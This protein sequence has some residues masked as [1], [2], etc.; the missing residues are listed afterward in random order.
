VL[1][2]SRYPTNILAEAYANR[3]QA[4]GK[5]RK[6]TGRVITISV[7]N[8]WHT[9]VLMAT[10]VVHFSSTLDIIMNCRS[11]HWIA[12][13]VTLHIPTTFYN[14]KIPFEGTIFSAIHRATVSRGTFISH[15][16]SVISISIAT[17]GRVNN[18]YS[19]TTT[20]KDSMKVTTAILLWYV[21]ATG[22]GHF[23]IEN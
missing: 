19:G 18:V 22:V 20:M 2:Y 13:T 17:G 5:E 9:Q 23:A 14:V 3:L 16:Q 11:W 1:K 10:T 21:S 12:T 7:P 6:W 15:H 8:M 4:K